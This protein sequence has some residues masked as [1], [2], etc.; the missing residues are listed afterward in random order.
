MPFFSVYFTH[1]L[2][3]GNIFF[4]K[5]EEIEL[6]ERAYVLINCDLGAEKQV[7]GEL[8]NLKNVKDVHGTLGGYDII[9]TVESKTPEKVRQTVIGQIRN[10]DHI[11]STLT[12]MGIEDVEPSMMKAELIPDIIPE[13]KKPLEPPRGMDEEE[14]DEEYDD[15][16]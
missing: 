9:A 8:K 12:L 13:E 10:L 15:E 16:E 7:I 2:R 4:S 6:M 5:E 14:F 3:F 1:V 11:R